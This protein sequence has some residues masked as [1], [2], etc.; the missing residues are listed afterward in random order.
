MNNMEQ[1]MQRI[2]NANFGNEQVANAQ[3]T[4]EGPRIEE[5]TRPRVEEES[6]KGKTS[7]EL[8]RDL[9]KVTPPKFDGRPIGDATKSWIIEMEKYFEL[10]NL[11]DETRAIWATY[12]LSGE[13]ATW[14]DNE[15]AH[16]NFQ[17]GELTWDIFLQFFQKKV[18]PPTFLRQ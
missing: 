8:G 13:A 2:P 15:R 5:V 17:L 10:R 9:K 4:T 16:N 11:Y 18:A 12:Q 6:N 7:K 1:E 14:W 3:H